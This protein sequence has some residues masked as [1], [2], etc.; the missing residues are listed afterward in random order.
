MLNGIMIQF[1]HWYTWEQGNL[2][3]YLKNEA[4]KLAD[5]GVTAVWLPP[6][7]KGTSGENSRGYDIYDLYDLGEFDQKGCVKTRYGTK[8]EYI[9]C[10]KTLQE[11]GITAIADIVLNHKGGG[12]ETEKVWVKKVNPENR[13]EFISDRF[14]IEAFTKFTFPGRN[15]QY[16]DFIW[17]SQCFSGVDY[18]AGNKETGIYSIQNEYGDGWE[19][20]IDVEKG[21]FDY[22]MCCDI[23]YRNQAVR[24]EIKNWGKWYLETTGF[25]GMRL[26]AIKHI[27]PKFINEFLDHMRGLKNDLF[28][29]GEYWAPGDLPLLK[30]YVDATQGRMS[31]FDASL[32]HNLYAASEKGK[33]YNMATIFNGSLVQEIPELAVT[34]IDNHDTQPLQALEAPVNPWF[35]A[36]AYALILLREKGYPCVFYPDLYGA[37]Y[38]DKG[39]DGNDYEIYM[40]KCDALEGLL[41]ARKGIAFGYQRDYFDH[42]NC[43]GWTRE[44]KLDDD[45]TACAVILSNGDNGTKWMEIGKRHAGKIFYDYLGYCTDDIQINQ[46]GWAEFRCNGGSVSVWIHR[47]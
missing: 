22:L 41:K 47:M 2:W 6:A 32:H 44:G 15:K 12:D 31:L 43:V 36:L 25:N 21:N 38:T 46:D 19:E 42:P 17:N 11:H 14:E 3:N 27:S 30:K 1:F 20:V 33:D 5:L 16:S 24:D 13:N 29:V 26:D 8:D 9:E 7:C 28:V 39:K 23:E 10:I 4:P 40:P 18:D 37:T 35:K 45:K 34:L